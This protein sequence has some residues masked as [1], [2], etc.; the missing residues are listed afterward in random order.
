METLL[1]EENTEVLTSGLSIEQVI[2]PT[3]WNEFW[4]EL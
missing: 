3:F 1:V 2:A 4:Q